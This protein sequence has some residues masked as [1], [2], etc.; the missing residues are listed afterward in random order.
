ATQAKAGEWSLPGRCAGLAFSPDGQT[1]LTVID[2]PEPQLV[3]WNVESKTVH[4]KV[5]TAP[6]LKTIGTTFAASRD[7]RWVAIALEGNRIRVMDL[8]SQRVAWEA[9]AVV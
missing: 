2:E 5:P 4:S 3:L 6:M 9:E 8:M 7:L 1:L